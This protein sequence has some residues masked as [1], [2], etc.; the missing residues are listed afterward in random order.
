MIHNISALMNAVNKGSFFN[1]LSEV[2][3]E[4]IDSLE[5]T[6]QYK[7][8]EG[9]NEFTIKVK[10]KQDYPG[11]RFQERYDNLCKIFGVKRLNSI[12][13]S[14]FEVPSD[15][16]WIS[17]ANLQ[18]IAIVMNCGVDQLKWYAYTFHGEDN[19]HESGLQVSV[20]RK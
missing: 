11:E 16:A 17:T 1:R 3:Q 5:Q 8:I 2:R 10:F 6:G 12:S 14:A 13:D 18:E 19:D 9:N 4:I 7:F 15:H 20:T